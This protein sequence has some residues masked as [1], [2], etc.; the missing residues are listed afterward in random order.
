MLSDNDVWDLINFIGRSP[1]PTPNS[2]I[3]QTRSSVIAFSG[4]AATHKPQ[5]WQAWALVAKA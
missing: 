4:Q 3:N 5:A 1:A 2:R